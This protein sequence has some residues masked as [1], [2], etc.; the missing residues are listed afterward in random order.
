MKKWV[1]TW[2]I[3]AWQLSIKNSQVRKVSRFLVC[4]FSPEHDNVDLSVTIR[5]RSL[6]ETQVSCTQVSCFT[7]TRDGLGSFDRVL[8]SLNL[9]TCW[10]VPLSGEQCR[11]LLRVSVKFLSS[12][13]DECT[14]DE[15]LFTVKVKR[16][17]S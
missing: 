2:N 5:L 13:R 12:Q 9:S 1:P 6:D 17:H 4:S 16:F 10:V 7:P 15:T 14:G 3:S 8:L 11:L